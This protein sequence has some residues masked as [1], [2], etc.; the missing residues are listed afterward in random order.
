MN[1]PEGGNSKVE[2]HSSKPSH[3]LFVAKAQALHL[4]LDLFS[5]RKLQRPANVR[6]VHLRVSELRWVR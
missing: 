3:L 4:P 1:L 5:D 2:L 6:D